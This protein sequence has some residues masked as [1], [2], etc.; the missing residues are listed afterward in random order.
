MKILFVSAVLPYPLHSGGQI[1][2]YNLLKRLV[3]THE[4]HLYSFIRSETEKKYLPD[5]RFCKSVTTVLRGR[6]WQPKYIYKT[7]TGSLPLL[8]SSYHN[9]RMVGFLADEISLGNYDLIHIEPGYVWPSVPTQHRVPIVVA[10]H[11][12]EHEVYKNLRCYS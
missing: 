7:L 2:I 1:R 5:L 10:E 3:D 4:I 8:W 12:I 11:N 6:V 9:S